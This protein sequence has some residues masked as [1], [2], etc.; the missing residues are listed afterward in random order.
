MKQLLLLLILSLV[1]ASC[2]LDPFLYNQSKLD[3]Y[4]LSTAIIPA[5][6]RTE[7]SFLSDGH[8]L[9]GFD[10]QPPDSLRIGLTVLYCHGNKDNI[11]E[12]WSRVERFYEMGIRCFIFDYQ[13]FGRSEGSPSVSGLAS[14]GRAALRFVLDSLHVGASDLFFYGYSLGNVVSIDL[15]ANVMNP[16]KLIAESPFAS[17]DAMLHSSTL[18]D[19]PGSFVVDTRIDN[20]AQISHIH[21][22]FLLLHGAQDEFVSWNDN[23]RVVYESAPQPKELEL[24]PG[25]DHT[26]IADVMGHANYNARILRFLTERF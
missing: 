11:G 6:A 1:L 26:N 3:H 13:G 14:D 19:L 10:V 23:G 4:E 17:T 8:R 15:A 16:L 25:A 12:Y 22:P 5:S 18:L 9:F 2:S 7:Y 20:A 21:T 24:V